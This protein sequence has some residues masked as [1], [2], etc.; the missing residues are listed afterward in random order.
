MRISDWSSD[1]CSSDLRHR[2]I[3]YAVGRCLGDV[4]VFNHRRRQCPAA[5]P[6][7]YATATSG[8]CGM[9]VLWY[10]LP[11]SLAFGGLG[12]ALFFWALKIGKYDDVS[13]AP[14]IILN[15]EYRRL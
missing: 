9:N 7:D 11:I 14:C 8:G 3:R 1:V 15:Y 10:L 4:R 2:G 12:P 13:G 6:P 5:W